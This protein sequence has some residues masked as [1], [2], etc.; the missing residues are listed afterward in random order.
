M[1]FKFFYSLSF[2]LLAS[3]I[4]V[5]AYSASDSTGIKYRNKGLIK[6]SHKFHLDGITDCETC[7][8]QALK[9]TSLSDTLLPTMDN[10]AQCHDVEDENNCKMCHYDDNFE[11][12]I[13]KKVN[14]TF[15]HS[16]HINKQKLKCET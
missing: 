15:N 3:A 10:C 12:L 16:F 8:V 2:F 11:P 5:K 4:V 14:L 7:H 13:Q 9:A 6:F 1:K